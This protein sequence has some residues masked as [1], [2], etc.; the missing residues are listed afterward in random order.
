MH[1][2]GDEIMALALPFVG[3]AIAWCRARLVR[4]K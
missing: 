1:V 4:W 3:A 2:R